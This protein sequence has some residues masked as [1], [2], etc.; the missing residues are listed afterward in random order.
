MAR[1]V[2]PN[3]SA[4]SEWL[5]AGIIDRA[6]DHWG[7]VPPLDGGPG[8]H[9]NADSETDTAIPDDDIASLSHQVS[10]CLVCARVGEVV[11]GQRWLSRATVWTRS[12][13]AERRSTI[14]T[15]R[16]SSMTTGSPGQLVDEGHFSALSL[17]AAGSHSTAEVQ[18]TQGRSSFARTCRYS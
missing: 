2:L 12:S 14:F 7:H 16:T 13:A 10:N 11:P 6:L 5:L 1:A 17:G 15:S 8:D 3:P 18:Q 9:E 4:R